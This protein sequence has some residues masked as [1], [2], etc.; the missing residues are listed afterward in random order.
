MQPKKSPQ[1]SDH[2][3]HQTDQ[4]TDD[5]AARS[6]ME[7]IDMSQLP[8]LAEAN[9]RLLRLQAEMQNLRNRTSRE[10]SDERRYAALP[11]LRDL[12]PVIDNINRAIEAAEKAG[13]AENLLAGFRLVKQQLES[14][15]G[16][17][18]AE[19]I[20]GEGQPFDP[21]FQEAI[22]HQPSADVPSGD[23][24]MVTLPGYKLHDRVIR[25]A[26]VIVSSGPPS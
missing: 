13:E 11:I 23:V 1:T 26:Q 6:A 18:D 4:A 14:I 10:I 2:P 9:D 22:L 25:P 24:M 7:T 19:P 5:Q 3:Q 17:Y 20:T 12:L 21:H 16:R 15:L 8:Q